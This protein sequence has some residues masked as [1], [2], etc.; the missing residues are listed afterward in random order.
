MA[1]VRGIILDFF[2]DLPNTVYHIQ[3]L[4]QAHAKD[5]A[6][7]AISLQFNE[8]LLRALEGTINWLTEGQNSKHP[9]PFARSDIYN[10]G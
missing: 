6:M 1:S 3:N 9:Y 8:A 5:A 2:G 7:Y 4:Q 10:S